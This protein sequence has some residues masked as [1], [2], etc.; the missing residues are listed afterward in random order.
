MH[1]L[2]RSARWALPLLVLALAPLP[3][4]AH[5]FGQRYDLP[6]PLTLYLTGAALAVALSFVVIGL[7]V[8]GAPS[9]HGYPTVDLTRWLPFR[10]LAYPASAFSVR[11][12]SSALLVLVVA[13]G[14]V[15]TTAAMG[16]IAPTLVWII[17]WVGVAYVSAL[18]GDVW[19]VLN[20]FDALFRGAEGL[21]RQ[22]TG[23]G[24]SLE[25][26]YP[27]RLG[28]WPAVALFAL[29]AWFELA[30]GR[31]A[32][33]RLLALG[34]LGYA[35]IT[36]AGM[37]VYGR[38]AWL[39]GGEAFAVAF[40]V[41][42]RFAP[43]EARAG[44]GGRTRL[45]LRPPGAGLLAEGPVHLSLAVFVLLMLSTVTY[46]GL[47]ATP[48][49]ASLFTTLHD[50]LGSVSL[51]LTLGMAGTAG[52]F[53]AVTGLTAALMRLSARGGPGVG[54]TAR[55]FAL[56]LVPIALA[57]HLAHYFTYLITQGQFIIPLASDPFGWDW[58]LL[59]SANYKV[60]IGLVGARFAWVLAIVAIVTG[61][62]VAVFVAH[63]Q[64]ARTYPT[65][66]AALRSQYPLLALMVG[67]TVVSL[68]II[69]Q[70]IMEVVG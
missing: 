35:L 16:N 53:V 15:G 63:V 4:Q 33:P 10:L 65:A 38:E 26:P 54:L 61:H 23:E 3:A 49:W 43:I 7:F 20:P 30:S 45:H 46:D 40:G 50:A 67:Y 25:R 13:A 31:A 29:F 9:A 39:R 55:T 11:V 47:T 2:F 27:A 12:V 52:A 21:A 18:V 6:V 34:T 28:H 17:W 56:S 44:D 32:E 37:A 62:V 70:P 1:R 64:A 22:L 5:G 59:G 42:A 51:V 68:W 69:A 66:L 19:R 41:L 24:L 8:R 36:W 14:L 58:N 48:L 57:Y 60:N